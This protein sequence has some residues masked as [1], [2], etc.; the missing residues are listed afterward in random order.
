MKS[1]CSVVLLASLAVWASAGVR[2]T[3]AIL[4]IGTLING[5]ANL[6][7][8]AVNGVSNTVTN[9]VQNVQTAVQVAQIG[10]Q[11]LWDNAIKPTIDVLQDSEHNQC[12]MLIF[13]FNFHSSY[14]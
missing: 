9:T 11:F 3:E 4:G 14:T 13:S 6:V 10:G 1:I 12:P 8:G 5:V 2:P 7:G